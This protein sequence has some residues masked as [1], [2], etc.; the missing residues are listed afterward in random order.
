M[1]HYATKDELCRSRVLL[2]YFGET[3][4]QPCGKCDVCLKE[5]E[6][7]LRQGE[8]ERIRTYILHTLTEQGGSAPVHTLRTELF[9][10]EKVQTTL[11]HLIL[12]EELF[13]QDGIISSK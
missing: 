12:E 11:Q 8:F 5:H 10:H 2:N 6:S 13:L 4:S 7:G 9:A 1:L 3:E